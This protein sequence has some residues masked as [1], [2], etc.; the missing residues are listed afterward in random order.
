MIYCRRR[1]ELTA[2]TPSSAARQPLSAAL[3]I[4]A[5]QRAARHPESD[6]P[7][8]SGVLSPSEGDA[9]QRRS[10]SQIVFDSVALRRETPRTNVAGYLLTADRI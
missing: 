3:D 7:R 9:P 2:F 8:A 5:V 1:T 4:N 10:N 6:F